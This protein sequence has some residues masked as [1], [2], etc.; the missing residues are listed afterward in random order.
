MRFIN[1]S[2]KEE[3]QKGNRTARVPWAVQAVHSSVMHFA[4]P[5]NEPREL[6]KKAQQL[7]IQT[8][9]PHSSGGAMVDNIYI[10]LET[11]MIIAHYT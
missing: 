3:K 11:I 8:Q 2:S 5:C 9:P 4:Q 10:L 7:Y 6:K 1:V